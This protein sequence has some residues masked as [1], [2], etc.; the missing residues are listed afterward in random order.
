MKYTKEE[1][2]IAKNGRLRKQKEKSVK[3]YKYYLVETFYIYESKIN[4]K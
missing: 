4:E 3:V 1:T 2:K